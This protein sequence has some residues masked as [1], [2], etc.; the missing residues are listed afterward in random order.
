MGL[1]V[2]GLI[3][4]YGTRRPDAIVQQQSGIVLGFLPAWG[5]V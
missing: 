5:V 2:L 1:T 4:I 3:L